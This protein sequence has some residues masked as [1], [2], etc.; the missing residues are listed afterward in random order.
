MEAMASG[1]PCVVSRIRGNVDFVKEGEGGYAVAADDVG[2]FTEKIS[3]LI[4]DDGLRA[5]MV[6][7]NLRRIKDFDIEAVKDMIGKI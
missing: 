4:R 7:R 2:G 1:L 5:R 3:E 6:E